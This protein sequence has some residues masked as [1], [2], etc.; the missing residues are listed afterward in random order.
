V[1]AVV[2]AIAPLAAACRPPAPPPPDPRP[3]WTDAG[4][5][6]SGSRL[7]AENLGELSCPTEQMCLAAGWTGSGAR[8]TTV[9]DGGRWRDV[10]PPG[11][12]DVRD[13]ACGS[14]TFCLALG[15]GAP[16]EDAT[17]NVWDGSAWH[18]RPATGAALEGRNLP[19]SAACEGPN[20]CWVTLH[21]ASN[22]YAVARFDGTTWSRA[23]LPPNAGGV[24]LDCAGPQACTAVFH[25]DLPMDPPTVY[26]WDG[27]FWRPMPTPPGPV[28]HLECETPTFCVALLR[29][30]ARP[31]EQRLFRWDG[32]AWAEVAVPA[33]GDPARFPEE[34]ACASRA[35]SAGDPGAVGCHI[36]LQPSDP[37]GPSGAYAYDGSALRPVARP[38]FLVD[39]LDC[40]GVNRC[41]AAGT[42]AGTAAGPSGP[43]AVGYW[44]GGAAWTRGVALPQ[45]PNA[46]GGLDHVS[47]PGETSCT[48]VGRGPDGWFL[49][50]WDGQRWT[51]ATPPGDLAR[52]TEVRDLDCG[53]PGQCTIVTIRRASGIYQGVLVMWRAGSWQ[54]LDTATIG[55]P[56]APVMPFTEV[57]CASASFCLAA[58]EV[59]VIRW[60]GRV[61]A[62][63]AQPSSTRFVAIDCLSPTFCLAATAPAG[64]FRWD[65]RAWATEPVPAVSGGPPFY[66]EIACLTTDRCVLAGLAG[67]ATEGGATPVATVRTALG[68]PTTVLAP[69]SGA[70]GLV[71]DL[72]CHGERCLVVVTSGGSSLVLRS[73]DLAANRWE[74]IDQTLPQP[75]GLSASVSCRPTWCLVVGRRNDQPWAMRYGFR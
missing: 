38:E 56:A 17:V 26:R 29:G 18:P 75:A 59:G 24:Y 45:S 25:G 62:R 16:G 7:V 74:R 10:T 1:V 13:P 40:P 72:A 32:G 3:G 4:A 54:V 44:D 28:A 43:Q 31:G 23:E 46:D 73:T 2:A 57:S 71:R 55:F 60:D 63:V 12:I 49:E 36:L 65:G 37:S 66:S 34:L 8:T 41:V 11:G 6:P 68:W 33:A 61:W 30:F 22:G 50:Q 51:V 70:P 58:G 39:D 20:A 42:T 35:A 15:P 69:D 48:A 14:P 67:P 9:Y 47:C 52:T 64:V 5:A 53:A 19:Y 27:V 21:G